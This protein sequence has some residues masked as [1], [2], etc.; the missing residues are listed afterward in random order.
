MII[1]GR[2]IELFALPLSTLHDT[3]LHLFIAPILFHLRRCLHYASCFPPTTSSSL[4]TIVPLC[5]IL[6][7]NAAPRGQPDL[8]PLPT[9][10]LRN[11]AHDQATYTCPIRSP[12]IRFYPSFKSK[13]IP[14][15]DIQ[16]ASIFFLFAFRTLYHVSHLSLFQ[17]WASNVRSTKPQMAYCNPCSPY[18]LSYSSSFAA[19]LSRSRLTLVAVMWAYI[20][21]A[22][23]GP[24]CSV[25]ISRLH[26]P[27][28]FDLV[29]LPSCNA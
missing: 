29:R 1:E 9:P 25:F 13:T 23:L 5:L 21:F 22:P 26:F 18:T 11:F 17:A 7:A 4:P 3:R 8:S 2:L 20:A 10:S 27:L 16:P 6:L 24:W 28:T 14:L 19:F 15:F 12:R